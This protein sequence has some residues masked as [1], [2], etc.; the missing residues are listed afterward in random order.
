VTHLDEGLGPGLAGRA[1]GDDEDPDGLDR[2]VSRLGAPARS[3]TE[4]GPGGLSGVEGVGLA[5]ATA[6]LSVR[7]IDL[8]DLDAH[9]AQVTS[10]AGPIRA[11]ALDADLGH[12]PE[13][14]EPSQQRFV[15]GRG[16]LEALCSEQP[17]ERIEGGGN[18]DEVSVDATSHP[19]RS[20]YDGHGHPF[21]SK[22]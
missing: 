22:V 13:G 6:L 19:T 11:R 3:A 17:A 4:G 21:L 15:T 7:S 9:S 10:Q 16:G 12:V 20:F 5:A 2:A 1:L 18:M 14:L 8:D